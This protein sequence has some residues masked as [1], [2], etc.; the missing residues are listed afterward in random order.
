VLSDS[1]VLVI[2]CKTE[3]GRDSN[4]KIKSLKNTS[5]GVENAFIISMNGE[6]LRQFIY[7]DIFREM[8]YSF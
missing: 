7:Q 6:V 2:F 5:G 8:D 3:I 4:G 1:A